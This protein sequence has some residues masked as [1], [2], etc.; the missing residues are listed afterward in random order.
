MLFFVWGPNV[1]Q[2][3]AQLHTNCAQNASVGARRCRVVAQIAMMHT[4]D[5]SEQIELSSAKIPVQGTAYCQ[6]W[7][8]QCEGDSSI[9]ID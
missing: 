4:A 8:E 5:L 7:S 2:T 3:D 6:R 9:D 1:S